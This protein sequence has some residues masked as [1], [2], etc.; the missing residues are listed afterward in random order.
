[1]DDGTRQPTAPSPG[2]RIEF[3]IEEFTIEVEALEIREATPEE[4]EQA[5]NAP[6]WDDDDDDDDD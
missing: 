6:A 1:M 4:V 3:Q 2:E 5:R